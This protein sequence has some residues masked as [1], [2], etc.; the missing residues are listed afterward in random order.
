MAYK[1][2]DDF[3]TNTDAGQAPL[4][5][6]IDGNTLDLPDASYVRDADIQRDGMDLV[7]DGPDGTII[8]EGYFSAEP[9]PNLTAPGGET[10]TPELVESFAHSQAQ[11]ADAGSMNDASPVG[12][13]QEVSGD[14]TVTRL[15]GSVEPIAQGTAIYQGDVVE[16]SGEGAVNIVFADETSFAVSEDARLAIDEY[17]YDPD[18]QSGTSN[19]SVL[20]G[21]FVFTSGL[22]GRDDPDDVEIDTPVGSIGIRG[23]IIMGDVDAG[24]ITVVEGAI[25][26]RDMQGHEMTLANQ[27]ETGKFMPNNGGIEHMGEMSAGHMSQKFVGVSTV[28]PELFSSL[29]D[30]DSESGD[31][32]NG[33]A[34]EG[35]P[36]LEETKPQGEEGEIVDEVIQ[37]PVHQPGADPF[38][39]QHEGGLLD[40]KGSID[41]RPGPHD[42]KGPHHGPDGGPDGPHNG[43]LHTG[44]TVNDPALP[45]FTVDVVMFGIPENFSGDFV[46]AQLIGRFSPST[47]FTLSDPVNY[48]LVNVTATTADV[49]YIGATPAP[50]LELG[51]VPLP[52]LGFSATNQS[53]AVTINEVV[54]VHVQNVNEQSFVVPL[55]ESGVPAE[56]FVASEG[57][58]WHLDLN[59]LFADVDFGD[60]LSYK[61]TGT[62]STQ[63][64]AV[65]AGGYILNSNID[66]AGNILSNY[67]TINFDNT[68][69]FSV[70]GGDT[71]FMLEIQATDAGGLTSTNNFN[72]MFNVYDQTNTGPGS[73][74]TL[75]PGQTYNTNSP[76]TTLQFLS[77]TVNSHV[78]TGA[79]DDNLQI[80]GSNNNEVNTGAD[81]DHV[82]VNSDSST[83]YIMT[84]TGDDLLTISGVNNHIYGMQ[85]NDTF[86]L[87]LAGTTVLGDLNGAGAGAF[88]LDGGHGG[89]D[90][91]KF[92]SNSGG[93]TIDFGLINNSLIKNFEKIEVFNGENDTVSLGYSDILAMTDDRGELKIHLDAGDTLNIDAESQGSGPPDIIG[94]DFHYAIGDVTLIVDGTTNVTVVP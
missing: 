33:E 13:V 52:T 85:D 74:I 93:D 59:E 70:F 16:T 35:D 91:L 73:I 48:Q 62:S 31:D 14:A 11:Y 39:G 12:A 40:G 83:N 64:N 46:V 63:F 47:T 92:T 50:D 68:T 58:S 81:N 22:I 82:T 4:T 7:L 2:Q 10:L 67:L 17:V 61:L 49:E 78:L 44:G 54:G 56:Y 80:A 69:D 86:D 1:T 60:T 25:V 3:S 75:A 71:N 28:A 51:G 24:E 42:G 45:P 23:T 65:D 29:N 18:S 26:L 21:V 37:E 20:K 9:A 8:I 94:G 72:V 36:A 77:S 55:A 34:G 41:F 87:I 6:T 53:G 27:F 66:G 30:A 57:S 32:S 76:M 90:V 88:D 15:D 43:P 38:T 84:G 89:F 5:L 19:F 79:G